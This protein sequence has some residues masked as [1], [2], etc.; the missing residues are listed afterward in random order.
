MPKSSPVAPGVRSFTRP[1]SPT[2]EP[3]CVTPQPGG[4]GSGVND[5]WCK[6]P[7]SVCI[8]GS[9]TGPPP[10]PP[11]P[12][13]PLPPAPPPPVLLLVGQFVSAA[14]CAETNTSEPCCVE[15]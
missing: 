6:D 13:L 10:L 15:Q 8:G 14:S 9:I 2:V 5:V 12:P 4:A 3:C 7:G 11:A 1:A